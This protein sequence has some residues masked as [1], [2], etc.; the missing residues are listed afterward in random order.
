MAVIHS[1]GKRGSY[2]ADVVS[3]AVTD[4]E[5]GIGLNCGQRLALQD[6]Q[7]TQSLNDDCRSRTII[8]TVFDLQR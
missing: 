2:F 8:L 1:Q 6:S 5:P 3:A 4:R 7:L